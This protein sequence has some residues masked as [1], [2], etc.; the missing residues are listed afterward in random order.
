[1]GALAM[2]Y[3]SAWTTLDFIKAGFAAVGLV[4]LV[5][6]LLG[7]RIEMRHNGS[8]VEM[9]F[10]SG[11]TVQVPTE[12]RNGVQESLLLLSEV[13]KG[14]IIPTLVQQHC[15]RIRALIKQHRV[16][17]ETQLIDSVTA[18]LKSHAEMHRSWF[19]LN[20]VVKENSLQ[21]LR[22]ERDILQTQMEIAHLEQTQKQLTDRG[23]HDDSGKPPRGAFTD[24]LIGRKRQWEE[25]QEQLRAEGITEDSDEWQ[26]AKSRYEN[27]LFHLGEER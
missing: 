12:V 23:K 2:E 15:A 17:Q 14:P 18:L 27:D 10:P 25:Q 5:Y 13:D 21:G 19:T 11:E 4:S 26:M 22:T 7:R 16:E 6:A 1:M 9:K 8:M 24:R 20:N 3:F